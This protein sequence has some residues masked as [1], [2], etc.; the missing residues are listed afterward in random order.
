MSNASRTAGSRSVKR[1]LVL[2]PEDWD[3]LEQL[4]GSLGC[5]NRRG[6]AVGRPSVA[7]LMRDLAR[8]TIHAR[9]TGAGERKP[10]PTL[11]G[12][13]AETPCNRCQGPTTWR[14]LP[15]LEPVCWACWRK[16]AKAAR[17]ARRKERRAGQAQPK[18]PS[19]PAAMGTL[20]DQAHPPVPAEGR[21]D[22]AGQQLEDSFEQTARVN[23]EVKAEINQE[24]KG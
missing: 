24:Q 17:L 18:Q 16:Q 3:R 8:G 5:L 19:M 4:A 12:S 21:G 20:W 22:Y 2:L 23:D 7:A 15:D 10:L 11:S 9:R 6:S 14:V 1:T 13:F